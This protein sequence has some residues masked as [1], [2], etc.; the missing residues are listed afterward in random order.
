LQDSKPNTFSRFTPHPNLPRK[1]GG[2]ASQRVC[3]ELRHM[4]GAGAAALLDLLAA[5]EAVG[6][7]E[8]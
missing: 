1:G 7:D 4:D 3:Q 8:S 6:E 5:A 2:D